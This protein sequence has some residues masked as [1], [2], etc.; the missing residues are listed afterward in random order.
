MTA[1][2]QRQRRVTNVG[3]LTHRSSID[4]DR[5]P[6]QGTTR[7]LSLMAGR[8]CPHAMLQLECCVY[9]TSGVTL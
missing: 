6:T 4:S 7:Y 1:N 8:R 3:R 2:V 9:A 5:H